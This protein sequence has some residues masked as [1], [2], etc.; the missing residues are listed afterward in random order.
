MGLRPTITVL[1][2]LCAGIFV[3]VAIVA[4]SAQKPASIE[5]AFP[6][7]ARGHVWDVGGAPIPG[8]E[9][10]VSVKEDDEV[11]ATYTDTTNATGGYSVTFSH[12][13]WDAGNTILVVVEFGGDSVE[14]STVANEDPVQY[15][16]VTMTIAIPEFSDLGGIASV[17]GIMGI[18]MMVFFARRRKT[19]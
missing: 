13:V 11:R 12:E 14:N 16:N 18:F 3:A 10:E 5:A 6:L 9:V 17:A 19:V 4:P 8:A 7:V 2:I 1:S 15:V